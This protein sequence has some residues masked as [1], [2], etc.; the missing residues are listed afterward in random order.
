MVVFDTSVLAIS[1]DAGA[2]VPLD[3]RTS[4]PIESCR[5]RINHLLAALS[6]NKTRVIIPTPVMA[7]YIVSGGPDKEKRVAQISGSKAFRVEPF[8]LR[9]AVEC[10]LIED[11]DTATGRLLDHNA[12]K[13]KIKFDRQILAVAISRGASTIYT[14]DAKLAS[15]AKQCG[16][17]SVLTWDLPMPPIDPQRKLE[18]GEPLPESDVV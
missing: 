16:I 18:Y 1:L 10:A 7:E 15:R 4:L 9:A 5:E 11:A 12:T 14:G 13:A 8:D 3:P 2:S 17:D 6:A